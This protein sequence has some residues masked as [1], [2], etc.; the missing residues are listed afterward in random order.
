[1]QKKR[2]ALI[3]GA[4]VGGIATAIRLAVKG[5]SVEVFEAN[6]FPGGKLSEI[7]QNGYRFDAGPSLFTMPQ[8]VSELFQL[9]GKK[10]EAFFTC[11]KMAEHCRYFYPDGTRFHITENGFYAGNS[12]VKDHVATRE[13]EAYYRN[14]SRI[15]NITSHVFLERSLHR[16]GTYLRLNTLRSILHLPQIDAFRSM[17]KANTAFFTHENRVQFAD[18]FATYNGS[19]PYSAPATLNVIPHL[20]HT[21]GTWFPAGGMYS[22]VKSL[23][24]LATSLGVRFHYEK[25]V[26]RI[27]HNRKKVLGVEAGGETHAADLVVSN[28]DVYFTYKNFLRDVPEFWPK[29]ILEQERS[30]SALIFYWG[31]KKPFPELGLH[32]IFFSADYKAEFDAIWKQKTI[33]SDPTVYLNISAKEEK[34]DA[35]EGCENWFVMINVPANSGQNWDA[36]IAEARKNVLRKLSGILGTEIGTLI[37]Q[38]SI[39]DP[40]SIESR[41]GAYTGAL[42]G[43]SS[44]SRF[45]AFLRHA[46]R[47]SKLKNLYFCGGSVHPG[48]G[49]PLSLLSAK[50]VSDW[51]GE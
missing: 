6:S 27:V 37:E 13:L 18:R 34:S 23:E 16:I 41:T 36:L 50:I 20:E 39:L 8:Y 3:I 32:N 43:N 45:A 14:S 9:A 29:R 5:F 48:G 25:P 22:I 15:W 44:N 12:E 51:V 31:I 19:D 30:S 28:A 35:P 1:M 2:K 17:H 46:N 21:Y 40:R 7:V 10:P 42:Y 26:S 11:K 47:S 33:G 4:G 24:T 49:I 38:E